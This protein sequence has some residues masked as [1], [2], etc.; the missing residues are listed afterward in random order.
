MALKN[1]QLVNK[2]DYNPGVRKNYKKAVNKK[3][4]AVPVEEYPD[5]KYKGWA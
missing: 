4:R 5:V 1:F 3:I 2:R